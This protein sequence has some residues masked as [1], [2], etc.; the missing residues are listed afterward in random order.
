MKENEKQTYIG[1]PCPEDVK[2]CDPVPPYGSARSLQK[3]QNEKP[4][5][6]QKGKLEGKTA[7]KGT[8][9][10]KHDASLWWH[11]AR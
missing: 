4:K 7:I 5:E 3:N 9:A 8:K 10:K 6:N 11:L 2:K 1:H